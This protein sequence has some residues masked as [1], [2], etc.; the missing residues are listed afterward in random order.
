MSSDFYT[1]MQVNDFKRGQ[2]IR[3]ANPDCIPAYTKA[4]DDRNLD[5][6]IVN[7]IGYTELAL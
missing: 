7:G 3:F 1:N 6:K 5:Y 4:L 2:P